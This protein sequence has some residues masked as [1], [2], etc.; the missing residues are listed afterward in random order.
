MKLRTRLFWNALPILFIYWSLLSK[1]SR[2]KK[3]PEYYKGF[4]KCEIFQ[5]KSNSLLKKF[6]IKLKVNNFSNV[7]DGP[8]LIIPNHSTYLDPLIIASALHNQGDGQKR[9]KN[10]GFIA[11]SESKQKKG[12]K[13]IADFINTYFLDYSKPREIL[14]TLRD[15]G[16]YVKNNKLCGVIFA[17][18]TRTRDGKLGEF[19]SGAF[20]V[21][22]SAYVPIIPVTINNACNAMDK[23]RKG[24]L[25]VEVTFHTPIKPVMFQTLDPKHIAENVKSIIASNY[26]DQTITS[27]ETI[28]NT[29][30][31]RNKK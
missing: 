3:M 27:K 7:P 14:E 13:K 15:F 8:C 22:Q 25:E 20:R 30:T 21:A 23:N 28:K 5:K 4:E 16:N 1:A 9:S 17:E 11:K 19:Q 29:Y 18:G 2:A 31:K 24:I 6:G 26:I 12:I 10:F